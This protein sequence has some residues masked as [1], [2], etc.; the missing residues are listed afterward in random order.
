M[1]KKKVE[2]YYNVAGAEG[3]RLVIET[4]EKVDAAFLAKR[5]SVKP[6]QITITSISTQDIE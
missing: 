5:D 2:V 1:K 6:A 4:A 3:K